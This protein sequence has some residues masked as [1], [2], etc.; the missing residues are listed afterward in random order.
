MA[1]VSAGHTEVVALLLGAKHQAARADHR[2]NLALFAAAKAGHAG[3]LRLLTTWPQHAALADSQV[4][5]R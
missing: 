1:S 4:G 3:V 5:C 2:D